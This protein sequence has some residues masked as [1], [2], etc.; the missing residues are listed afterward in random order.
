MHPTSPLQ[1]GVA[2]SLPGEHNNL[3]P[4]MRIQRVLLAEYSVKKAS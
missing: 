2:G 4:E 1:L 3:H